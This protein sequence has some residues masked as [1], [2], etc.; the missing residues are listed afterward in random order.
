MKKER[1]LEKGIILGLGKKKKN[2]CSYLLV[3]GIIA[4]FEVSKVNFVV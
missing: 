2:H 4:L 1:E 3:S